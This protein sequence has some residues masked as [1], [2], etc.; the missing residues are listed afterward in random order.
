MSSLLSPRRKCILE[1]LLENGGEAS[2]DEIISG[3]LSLENKEVNYKSRKSVYVSL[4]QTHL[5]RLE[6]E[7]IV[8]YDKRLGKIILI[9]L[10]DD[11]KM[12]VETVK[13]FDIPWSVYYLSLSI[14]MLFLGFIFNSFGLIVASAIFGCS[15]AINVLTQKIKI[16]NG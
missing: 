16:K 6:K 1:Q 3:I 8:R 9:N 13:K 4:M 11:L 7:G 10:P 2:V 14:L 12:Y 5:P 15:S